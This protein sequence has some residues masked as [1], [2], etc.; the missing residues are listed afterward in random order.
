MVGGTGIHWFGAGDAALSLLECGVVAWGF[1]LYECH[2]QLWSV[3]G[4]AVVIMSIVSSILGVLLPVLLGKTIGLAAPEVLAFAAR[5]T[6]LALAK[7]AMEALGGN[8]VVNAAVVVSNG[9]L[10]QLLYPYL[11]DKLPVPDEDSDKTDTSDSD[12]AD[13]VGKH[14]TETTSD[15]AIIIAIGTAIGINGAAMGVAY[16]CERRSRAAPY[17]AL[18]MASFGGATV[19]FTTLAPFTETL[20]RLAG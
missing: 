2:R 9:I 4:L 19:C 5:S 16:L 18:A 6:T 8:Q 7:P 1:K 20:I 10:G 15:S 12:S 13:D 17:A 14:R 3:A 11:L